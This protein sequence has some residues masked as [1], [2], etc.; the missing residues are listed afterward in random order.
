M[1]KIG[2]DQMT[3]DCQEKLMEIQ[4]FVARDFK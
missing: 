4:Y 1:E 3:E 2:T